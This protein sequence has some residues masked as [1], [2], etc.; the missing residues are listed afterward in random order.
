MYIYLVIKKI[1]VMKNLF[2]VLLL[3]ILMV[4]AS[5]EK[6]SVSESISTAD[7]S[8]NASPAADQ[9]EMSIGMI[10]TSN[11]DFEELVKALVYVDTELEA[12]LVDLFVYGTDNYTVFAPNDAAFEDLYTALGITTIEDLPADLVLDVLLYHVTDGRRF[13]N[14]V[15][16]KKNPKEI[17]TLLGASFYVN[18]D[19]SIDAIGNESSIIAADIAATNG[20]IHVINSV[21]LPI[22]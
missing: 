8:V 17:E 12:G 21:L 15:V 16:P 20:V 19:G 6:E 14:S 18:Y 10:A 4:F 13:S 7:A 2:N 22:E 5:C 11:E 1:R 9:G 3:A